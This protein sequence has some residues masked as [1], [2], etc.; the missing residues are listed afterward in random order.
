MKLITLLHV[1]VLHL[2]TYLKDLLMGRHLFQGHQSVQYNQFYIVVTFLH[3]Q[4]YITAS[5]SL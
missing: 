5:C 1:S 2:N 4:L 3:Y